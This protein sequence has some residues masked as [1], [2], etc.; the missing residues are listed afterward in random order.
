M[1]TFLVYTIES[2]GTQIAVVKFIKKLFWLYVSSEIL[3]IYDWCVNYF[4]F[5]II[6]K[7][8]FFFSI[9]CKT[10]VQNGFCA[11]FFNPQSRFNEKS[12]LRKRKTRNRIDKFVQEGEYQSLSKPY[13][14]TKNAKTSAVLNFDDYHV[15]ERSKQNNKECK[16]KEYR[17]TNT[18]RSEVGW[19]KWLRLLTFCF[20]FFIS[21][22][23]LSFDIFLN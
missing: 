3:H 6:K 13:K 19:S 16:N 15:N 18:H 1:T 2:H 7:E 23:V 22:L 4:Y 21:R 20:H 5:R 9:L 8:I 14:R 11:T 17:K 12:V 10:H